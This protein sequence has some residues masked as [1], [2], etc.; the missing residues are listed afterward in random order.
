[1]ALWEGAP[2]RAVLCAGGPRRTHAATFGADWFPDFIG[3]LYSL[4]VV[5]RPGAR[6]RDPHRGLGSFRDLKQLRI[7]DALRA[8]DEGERR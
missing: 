3:P 6:L 1:M 8:R 2:F 4:E 5:G 7:E